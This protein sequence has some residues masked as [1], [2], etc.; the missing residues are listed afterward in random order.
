M[1]TYYDD[2]LVAGVGGFVLATWLWWGFFMLLVG[3]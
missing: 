3:E 2:L 1:T